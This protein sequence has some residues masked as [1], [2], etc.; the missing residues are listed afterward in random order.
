MIRELF[1]Q[2]SLGKSLRQVRSLVVWA[3]DAMCKGKGGQEDGG[4]DLT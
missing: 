1:P 3:L 4:G 2:G